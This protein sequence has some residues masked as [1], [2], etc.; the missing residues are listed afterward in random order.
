MAVQKQVYSIA[1]F[2]EFIARP[3]NE[4]RLFELID[5]E[6]VEKVVT[7]AHGIVAANFATHLNLY[8]WQRP[9]GRV[10]VEARHRPADDDEN[11]RLPDVSFVADMSKAVVREGAVLSMPDLAIEIKSPSDS[12]RKMRE[13]ARYYLANGTKLV[14]LAFPEQRVIEVY[15]PADEYILGEDEI[16]TGGDVLPGFAVPV[17][18]LF[19]NI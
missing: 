14:W 9:I 15:T 6:I 8:A 17:R 11:D 5:G 13:K 10:A 2:E 3:E 16:L 19:R 12:L 18:D 1:Q 7:Q 4:E